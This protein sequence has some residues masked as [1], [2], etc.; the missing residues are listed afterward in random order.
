[1]WPLRPATSR[2]GVFPPHAR[3]RETITPIGTAVEYPLSTEFGT[4]WREAP[5]VEDQLTIGG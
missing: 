5:E 3:V 2:I 1:M 4:Q